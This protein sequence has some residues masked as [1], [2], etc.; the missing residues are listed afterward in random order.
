MA[1]MVPFS[2]T[3]QMIY[4]Q[5]QLHHHDQDMFSERLDLVFD[6]GATRSI[7]DTR[8]FKA[9]GYDLSQSREVKILTA[10]RKTIK[11][12]ECE[13]QNILLRPGPLPLGKKKILAYTLHKDFHFDGFLGL[14]LLLEFRNIFEKDVTLGPN[15]LLTISPRNDAQAIV[16]HLKVAAGG[17]LKRLKRI[18][19]P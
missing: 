15:G 11:T 8:W 14:D 12:H 9:M 13:V 17:V 2:L 7:I 18:L 10:D 3:R 6:S 5:A 1:L 19:I 16:D 4:V